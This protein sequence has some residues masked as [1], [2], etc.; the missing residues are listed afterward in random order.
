MSIVGTSYHDPQEWKADKKEVSRC[1]ESIQ[2]QERTILRAETFVGVLRQSIDRMEERLETEKQ[3]FLRENAP[4]LGVVNSLTI[5]MDEVGKLQAQITQQNNNVAELIQQ[6]I[7]QKRATAQSGVDWYNEAAAQFVLIEY[8]RDYLKFAEIEMNNLRVRIEQGKTVDWTSA[9]MQTQA[10]RLLSD[11]YLI[12]LQVIEHKNKYEECQQ[13][14]VQQAMRILEQASE[15]RDKGE[16][17]GYHI[18]QDVDYWTNNSLR[19][20][21]QEVQNILDEITEKVNDSDFQITDLDV[22]M[23]R[24][25]SLAQEKDKIIDCAMENARRSERVQAEVRHAAELLV[26]RHDFKL[27]G[28]NYELGDER[29]PFIA[30]MR[31]DTDGME[32][33]FVCGYDSTTGQYKLAHSMNQE[34]YNDQNVRDAIEQDLT[35]SLIDA[36]LQITSNQTCGAKNMT[37][38]DEENPTVDAQTNA[39]LNVSPLGYAR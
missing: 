23:T 24:L 35:Q 17:Y 38:Y 10:E 36:G 4:V 29:R 11:V 16:L 20:V 37:A 32:V 9:A 6:L 30:R 7:D 39:Q 26:D 27:V 14:C 18:G 2:C 5:R 25:T 19:S 28:A 15:F 34:A 8:N 21:E 22:L 13:K 12:G 33:E 3:D 31:R 1:Q